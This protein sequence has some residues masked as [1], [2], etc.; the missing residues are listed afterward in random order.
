M[1]A[2]TR[3]FNSSTVSTRGCCFIAQLA[4]S[5]TLRPNQGSSKFAAEC[6]RHS[7]KA[8]GRHTT[9][10]RMAARR[11]SN[12]R[13][14]DLCAGVLRKRGCELVIGRPADSLGDLV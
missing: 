3:S 9:P 1:I 10:D 8:I 6:S 7:Q 5:K 12:Q 11:K 4:V 14:D 13:R 2:A